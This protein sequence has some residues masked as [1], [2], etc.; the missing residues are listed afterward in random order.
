[1]EREREA[2]PCY[3]IKDTFPRKKEIELFKLALFNSLDLTWLSEKLLLQY[4]LLFFL[5][6]LRVVSK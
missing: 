6:K 1:M 4:Y 3:T 2:F 5:L